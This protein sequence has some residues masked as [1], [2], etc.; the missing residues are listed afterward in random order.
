MARL[1][2]ELTQCPLFEDP[3]SVRYDDLLAGIHNIQGLGHYGTYPCTWFPRVV[4]YDIAVEDHRKEALALCPQEFC[5][6]LANYRQ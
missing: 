2:A 4:H 3:A 5:C 1:N 6:V